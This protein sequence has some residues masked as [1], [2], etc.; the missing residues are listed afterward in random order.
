MRFF[1][2][3]ILLILVKP[4]YTKAN[5][6]VLNGLT[7]QIK[8]EKGKIYKGNIEVQNI[9]KTT[10]NVKIYLQD[11]S[12]NSD[13]TTD[14]TE[15]GTNKS[16]NSNWLKFNTNYLELNPGQKSEIYF[17][18]SVP[19]NVTEN[20]SYWSTCIVEPV[21]EV[22]ANSDNNGIQIHSIVRYA[23]QIITDYSTNSLVS[24]IKFKSI[25]VDKSNHQRILNIAL[26]NEGKV[27]CK[28]T[29]SLEIYNKNETSKTEGDFISQTM[30]LL[31]NASK[32]FPINISDLKNGKYKVIAFAKDEDDNVFA[33]EFELDV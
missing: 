24:D 23:I 4:D 10:K 20:G 17:E 18:I 28:P 13:G 25:N 7:H 5:I 21:E 2:L 14:Y 3:L 19:E 11:Y 30:S 22:K 27:Y 15:P 32:T 9:G 33:I 29:I 26:S 31:P 12:Y 1:I 8:T 6:I 16:T